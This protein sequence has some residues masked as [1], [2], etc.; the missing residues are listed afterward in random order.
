MFCSFR[1]YIEVL[2]LSRIILYVWPREEA[3][4]MLLLMATCHSNA[5]EHH[6][7]P[8]QCLWVWSTGNMPFHPVTST[9]MYLCSC[10]HLAYMCLDTLLLWA[11][12]G[13]RREEMLLPQNQSTPIQ[14]PGPAEKGPVPCC[15]IRASGVYGPIPVCDCLHYH[16]SFHIITMGCKHYHQI[17]LTSSVSS[18]VSRRLLNIGTFCPL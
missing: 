13:T 9:L 16:S 17:S 15:A 6:P 2:D 10:V 11:S 1:V 8:I 7:F 14:V 12:L 5:A 4:L 3:A 18:W